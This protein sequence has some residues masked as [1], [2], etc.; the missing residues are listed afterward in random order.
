MTLSAGPTNS[1][2]GGAKLGNLKDA[3]VV[4]VGGTSTD[5]GIVRN[6]YPRRC[7]QQSSI[8]GVALN[9]AL[10]DVQAIAM[11]GGSHVT[12]GDIISIGPKSCSYRLLQDGL[13]FGGNQLTLTDI[14]LKLGIT[15][16]KGSQ[17]E[18]ISLS[19][20]SCQQVMEEAKGQVKKLIEKIGIGE[21][22]LP[23]VMI[24]GGSSL[25]EMYHN[26]PFASVANAYGAAMAEVS[27]TVD[28]VV[29]LEKR[30]E[31]LEKLSNEAINGAISKGASRE[32]VTIVD[33]KIIP[34]HYV[35]GHKSRVVV[36]ASGSFL[37][38]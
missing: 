15:M 30:E 33:Q 26:P 14:A 6:G 11:G 2:V 35:P 24:G 18:N 29:C 36:T 9:D 37:Q 38:P 27:Y 4:D 31:M 34:Y 5:V 20:S 19:Q 25:F 32:R 21:T 16:I 1:F 28:T 23:V 10:P 7:L 3:I 22:D 8:G 12:H 13:A 17:V